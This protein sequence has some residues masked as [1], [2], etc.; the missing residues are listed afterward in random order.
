MNIHEATIANPNTGLVGKNFIAVGREY[1]N[2]KVPDSVPEIEMRDP[3]RYNMAPAS[4]LEVFKQDQAMYNKAF[5]GPL[6]SALERN[7]RQDVLDTIRGLE[8]IPDDDPNDERDGSGLF[9]GDHVNPRYLRKLIYYNDYAIPYYSSNYPKGYDPQA[10]V[11]AID[12]DR[13]RGSGYLYAKPDGGSLLSSLGSYFFNSGEKSEKEKSNARVIIEGIGDAA[14]GTIKGIRKGIDLTR[15]GIEKGKDLYEKAKNLPKEYKRNKEIA[16]DTRRITK[17]DTKKNLKEWWSDLW[18]SKEEKKKQRDT[19]LSNW[20]EFIAKGKEN[21]KRTQGDDEEVRKKMANP[22]YDD[23]AKMKLSVDKDYGK[24]YKRKEDSAEKIAQRHLATNSS[25]FSNYE[26]FQN[27]I[28]N[29][30]KVSSDSVAAQRNS[31]AKHLY[32]KEYDKL[33]KLQKRYIKDAVAKQVAYGPDAINWNKNLERYLNSNNK[34][35]TAELGEATD[36]PAVPNPVIENSEIL[37][38]TPMVQTSMNPTDELPPD[39]EEPPA[40]EE[41]E[42]DEYNSYVQPLMNGLSTL[43]NAASSVGTSA[44]NLFGGLKNALS[45]AYYGPPAEEKKEKGKGYNL[46]G[47][48]RR[49]RRKA[50]PSYYM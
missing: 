37:P 35:T 3:I 2:Y 28:K 10:L 45:N 8:E 20:N 40:K 38:K 24:L 9:E 27:A 46:N 16:A 13:G 47:R 14:V 18:K 22:T 41:E 49:R 32:G 7:G 15:A 33:D 29:A 48:R 17:D 30:P 31:V 36:P 11:N 39:V 34:T 23:E 1:H 44:Y 26:D 21:F 6:I 12:W 5:Q 4:F 25:L 19:T 43:G 50:P 42:N